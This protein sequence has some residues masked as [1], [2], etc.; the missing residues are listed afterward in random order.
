LGFGGHSQAAGVSVTEQNFLL[1]E[2]KINDFVKNEYGVIDS[3]RKVYAEWDIKGGISPRFANEI[4]MLEP[5]GTANKRPLFTSCVNSVNSI[6]LRMGSNHYTFNSN[7]IEMLDFNGQCHVQT[8]AMPIDKKVLFEINVSTYKGRQSIKGYVRAVYAEYGD[9]SALKLHIFENEL[10]KLLIE[11]N[12]SV[13]NVESIDFQTGSTLYVVSD[14]K[15]I[16]EHEQIKNLPISLFE[17]E[18]KNFNEEGY[19]RHRK[20]I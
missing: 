16:G 18:T 19:F 15:T 17:V 9:F 7:S 20:S 10:K 11:E 3:K 5:F 14:P 8:L 13:E 6:P 4:D 12:V 1:F 2:K